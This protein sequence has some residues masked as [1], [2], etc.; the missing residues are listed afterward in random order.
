MRELNSERMALTF[1]VDE[2]VIALLDQLARI[3]REVAMLEI[4]E[5]LRE[6]SGSNFDVGGSY[7]E[8]STDHPL[9]R[10]RGPEDLSRGFVPR[11]P[12]PMAWFGGPSQTWPGEW[13]SSSAPWWNQGGMEDGRFSFYQPPL[14]PPPE[15]QDGPW[16]PPPG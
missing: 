9:G 3:S 16:L 7:T 5:A 12:S 15:H 10:F 2:M 14:L 1:E 4:V 11:R 8:F 13:S 6:S